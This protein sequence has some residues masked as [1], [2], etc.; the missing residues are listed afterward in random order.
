MSAVK[1]YRVLL[2]D[3]NIAGL[4]RGNPNSNPNPNPDPNPDLNPH[5]NPNPN[6]APSPSRPGADRQESRWQAQEEA[7]DQVRC[8][9]PL[10]L[11]LLRLPPMLLLVLQVQAQRLPCTYY[12]L[13]TTYSLLL[14][15]DY[16]YKRDAYLA[17]VVGL[18]DSVASWPVHFAKADL[19]I[20]AVFEDLAVK[21][22]VNEP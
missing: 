16:R 21:H 19:V 13:L 5:P 1:D 18:T 20:E 9:P 4:S 12:L 17:A 7:D 10:H 15:T 14:T 11:P 22:K 6:P 8:L 2:K 3:Q